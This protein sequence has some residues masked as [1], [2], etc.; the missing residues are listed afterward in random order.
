[1]TDRATKNCDKQK[2]GTFPGNAGPFSR[3]YAGKILPA[4]RVL[5]L[6]R[7][8]YDQQK[9]RAMQKQRRRIR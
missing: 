9:R 2:K 5:M 3:Y 4:C 6:Q 1:M 7:V 8:K